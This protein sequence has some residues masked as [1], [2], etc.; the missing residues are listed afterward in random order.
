[1]NDP[2]S[3]YLTRQDL[4]H[5]LEGGQDGF[6]GS[7]AIVEAPKPTSDSS[8]V[9]KYSAASPTNLLLPRHSKFLT[10]T[11]VANLLVVTAVAPDSPAERSGLTVGDRIVAVGNEDFLGR[12]RKEV[13]KTLQQKYSVENYFGLADLTIAK[14]IFV[15]GSTTTTG[16]DSSMVVGYR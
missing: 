11:R 14:P 5:E 13:A 16:G 12:T 10:L 2:Y 15:A 8:P 9:S 3:K 1:L 7:G 6:L 4:K